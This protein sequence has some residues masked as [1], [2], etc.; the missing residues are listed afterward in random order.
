LRR[1]GPASLLIDYIIIGIMMFNV[2]FC[3]GELALLYP[4]SGGFY[5]LVTRFV[6][7]S[8]GFAVSASP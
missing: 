5:T 6:D 1:G 2:V 3:L 7:P 8:W 4:V